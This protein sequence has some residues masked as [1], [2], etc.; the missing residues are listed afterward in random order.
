MAETFSIK[1]YLVSV[2]SV[3]PRAFHCANILY[4]HAINMSY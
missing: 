4:D 1:Y 2:V 3:L